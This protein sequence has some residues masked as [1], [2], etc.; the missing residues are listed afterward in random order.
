MAKGCPGC[1]PVPWGSFPSGYMVPQWVPLSLLPL[2]N[3]YL[4][5]S[6][7]Q[8]FFK[9]RVSGNTQ[10]NCLKNVLVLYVRIFQI[11]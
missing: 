11:M 2:K 7:C 5:R 6:P 3:N 9:I 8:F 10:G 4:C 1:G